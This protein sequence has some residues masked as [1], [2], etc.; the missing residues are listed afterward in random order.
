VIKKA[1]R[2]KHICTIKNQNM[3]NVFSPSRLTQLAGVFLITAALA[4]SG[5]KKDYDPDGGNDFGNAPRKNVPTPFVGAFTYVTSTGGYVDQY[6]HYTPGVAHGLTLQIN[7]N[8]TGTSLYHV[9]KGSYSGAVTT[10]EVRTKCTYE[11]TKT[12]N[13]RADII[14]HYVS[15]QNFQD[16]VL[17]HD[18]DAS[19]L[20][21]N[22][23]TVWNDVEHGTTNEGKTYFIVGEGNNTAQFTEQ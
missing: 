8:G 5:C 10:Y 16:G 19:K 14:I 17:R 9:E 22:G 11:I 13:N 21:P 18:L 12:S 7:E 15:G 23:D 3:L 6:G 20:Y 2:E 1:A 4:F